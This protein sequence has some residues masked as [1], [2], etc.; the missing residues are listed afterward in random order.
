MAWNPQSKDTEGTCAA[1]LVTLAKDPCPA[2]LTTCSTLTPWGC[3]TSRAALAVPQPLSKGSTP[4]NTERPRASAHTLGSL[5]PGGK[6]A[7]P[8]KKKK[9]SNGG[10]GGG[11]GPAFR[12]RAFWSGFHTL[13]PH[14]LLFPTAWSHFTGHPASWERSL[15][16]ITGKA[17]ASITLLWYTFSLNLIYRKTC[18]A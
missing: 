2:V 9:R 6:W 1:L 16:F 15:Q 8:K 5:A 11:W 14:T 13:T 18:A 10:E 4:F 17:V 12:Q 3:C 7:D